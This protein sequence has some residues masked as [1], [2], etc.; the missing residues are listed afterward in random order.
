M[1][2]SLASV[3]L[4]SG[5]LVGALGCGGDDDDGDGT[6][7]AIAPGD[8]DASRP[9][10]PIDGGPALE[11]GMMTVN[12]RFKGKVGSEDLVCGQRY[13][14]LGSSG[15]AGKAQ[16]F[17]FFVHNVRLIGEGGAEV[18]VQLDDK[19]PFQSKELALLDFTDGRGSCTSGA[20]QSNTVL[21]GK[22]PVG[23]YTGIAFAT[24]V[25]ET[26]NH[27]D[28]A[29]APPPLKAP[30]AFWTWRQGYRFVLAELNVNEG[31]PARD[32]GAD[33]G[34]SAGHGGAVAIPG[35]V[36]AHFGS[37]GCIGGIG[38]FS[39]AKPNRGEIKLASFDPVTQSVV[40]DLGALFSPIDLTR[41]VQCHGSG[42]S[43]CDPMLATFGIDLAS[44]QPLATQ[45]VFRAE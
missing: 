35:L 39:C 8:L 31:L 15:I 36:I 44:G 5:A 42:G 9:F 17:R 33:P 22:V 45:Q 34:A 2:T 13:A 32:G 4:V 28:P 20:A 10:V 26:L 27:A 41:A 14:A 3:A 37:E 1:R 30:G 21:H 12:L 19:P 11:P 7:A 29:L 25:P 6:P 43:I 23:K 38:S 16:D 24:G 40:A 18:P